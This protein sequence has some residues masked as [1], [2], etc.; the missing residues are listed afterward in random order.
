[1]KSLEEPPPDHAVW[2]SWL[3]AYRG[4]AVC[5]AI[6]T[7]LVE[8]LAQAPE[9]SADVARAL[10]LHPR[11][12]EAVCRMLAATGFLERSEHGLYALTTQG[13]AYLISGSLYS[14]VPILGRPSRS[15]RGFI[16]LLRG[17]HRGA[18]ARFTRKWRSG[19]LSK[20]KARAVAAHM[21]AHTLAVA[22]LAAR[23]G[24]FDNVERLLDV[25][26]GAGSFCIALA[27]QYPTMELGLFELPALEAVAPSF[28]RE[29]SVSNV[30]FEFGNFF[31]DDLPRGYD[32]MLLCNVL[33]DWPPD[34]A[35]RLVHSVCRALPQG[36]RLFIC[37]I[38]LEAGAVGAAWSMTM[39]S[40]HRSQQFSQT[41][42]FGMLER[43]GFGTLRCVG[44]PNTYFSL[45]SGA[46]G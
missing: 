33:H 46:K 20:A 26:G 3:S 29:H 18:G 5:T 10:G 27:R 2:D 42:L 16:G 34:D 45:V 15:V 31:R 44:V 7:G 9:T 19:R 41:E 36:G 28:L 39:F 24:E 21:H 13:E 22:V 30:R 43:A 1:M 8:R 40:Q 17:G 4:L 32:A 23:A 37:E 38:L 35:E 12:T 25:G 6:Q 14:W 11:G